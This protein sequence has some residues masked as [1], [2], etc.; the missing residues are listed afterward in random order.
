MSRDE[1][2][3]ALR[4]LIRGSVGTPGSGDDIAN[5]VSSELPDGAQCFVISNRTLYRFR[6]FS[7]IA[8][9]GTVVIAPN[10]G[11]GRWVQEGPPAGAL[12]LFVAATADNTIDSSGGS[13]E[14]LPSNSVNYA[15][16]V[17]AGAWTFNPG[18]CIA[19]YNGP[20]ARYL[21]DLQVTIT[22][23]EAEAVNLAVA[24]N[25]DLTGSEAGFAEGEQFEDFTPTGAKTLIISAQRQV[26]LA[27]GDNIR[28]KFRIGNTEADAAIER[29]TLSAVAF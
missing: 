8:A 14:W 28:P 21:C 9:S 5:I 7:T 25:D 16:Q 19:T 1:S 15:M 26:L 10:A 12:G 17:G 22:L 11:G 6:K 27:P 29:L 4:L 20:A 3:P 2:S 23:Q 24:L 13:G 18:S